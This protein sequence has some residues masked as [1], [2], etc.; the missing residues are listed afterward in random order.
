M[1][2]FSS[3]LIIYFT[4]SIIPQLSHN[5]N[6]SPVRIISP[7]NHIISPVIGHNSWISVVSAGICT[8]HL[9]LPHVKILDFPLF[10]NAG[11]GK[12]EMQNK[13]NI[14]EKSHLEY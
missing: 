12:M 7:A 10:Q 14:I 3:H 9:F 8:S 2:Q 13:K 1:Q 6:S 11:E 5:H 4:P